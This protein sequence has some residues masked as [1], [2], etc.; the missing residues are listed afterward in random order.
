MDALGN[1]LRFSLWPGQRHDSA[2]AADLIDGL[3][4][5][6]LLGDKA[7]DTDAI[8][9]AL[10]ARRA[11]AV[12]PSKADRKQPIPHDPVKYRWRC[13]IENYFN[14]IKDFRSVN[15]RY[16]KTDAS[17]RATIALAAI[18]IALR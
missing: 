1:L 16:D 8:R 6:A 7:F 5:D 11:E 13:L 15:T 9:A 10:L 14:K 3:S 2:G 4:F 12:I 17:F 18:V